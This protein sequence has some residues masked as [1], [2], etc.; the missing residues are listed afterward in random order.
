MEER[1]LWERS[2]AFSVSGETRDRQGLR[3]TPPAR[4]MKVEAG[5]R[6]KIPVPTF[7]GRNL[8]AFDVFLCSFSKTPF[9]NRNYTQV[10]LV[11]RTRTLDIFYLFC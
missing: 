7:L 11:F 1:A 9:P 8:V 6:D 3:N 5:F 10:F 4:E 2:N